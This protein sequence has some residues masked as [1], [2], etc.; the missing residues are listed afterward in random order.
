MSLWLKCKVWNVDSHEVCDSLS[1]ILHRH[2]YIR[3]CVRGWCTFF[4]PEQW[5]SIVCGKWKWSSWSSTEFVGSRCWFEYSNI[6]CKWCE[7]FN[8]V[9]T[10]RHYKLSWGDGGGYGY[11]HIPWACLLFMSQYVVCVCACI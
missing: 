2:T 3:T 9:M 10:P 5:N 11:R 1:I 8:Y 6:W 7:L 4:L